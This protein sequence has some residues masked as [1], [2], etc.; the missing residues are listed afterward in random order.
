MSVARHAQPPEV[1]DLSLEQIAE[2]YVSRFRDRTPDWEAFEDAKIDSVEFN[3][4]R[5]YSARPNCVELKL[6]LS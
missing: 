1:A 3:S 4:I 5:L 6:K 2:R